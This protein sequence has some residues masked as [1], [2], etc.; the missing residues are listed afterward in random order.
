[1]TTMRQEY[2]YEC[3]DCSEGKGVVLDTDHAMTVMLVM[4]R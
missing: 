1:M 2:L 4:R 3:T